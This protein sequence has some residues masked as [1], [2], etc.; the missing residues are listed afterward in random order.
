M[1]VRRRRKKNK[2]LFSKA[3][4]ITTQNVLET[5]SHYPHC[6]I[7]FFGMQEKQNRRR[8]AIYLERYTQSNTEKHTHT[9]TRVK[10]DVGEQKHHGKVLMGRVAL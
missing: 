2:L 9:H 6:G 7:F 8:N 1:T 10:K 3:D 4:S 5:T